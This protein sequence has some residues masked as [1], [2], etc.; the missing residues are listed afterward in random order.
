M[1]VGIAITLVGWA[2][3]SG[4]FFADVLAREAVRHPLVSLS[5]ELR[6]AIL[7]HAPEARVI[8]LL[9]GLTLV[10]YGFALTGRAAEDESAATERRGSGPTTG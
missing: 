4:F 6:Q 9:S 5:A 10:L 1:W 2:V 8:A 3:T 7:T